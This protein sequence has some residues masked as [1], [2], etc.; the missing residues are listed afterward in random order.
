MET[1][2]VELACFRCGQ[3][4]PA[5]L[6]PSIKLIQERPDLWLPLGERPSRQIGVLAPKDGVRSGPD[7]PAAPCYGA[8]ILCGCG[9]TL[10]PC[11]VTDVG[12]GQRRALSFALGDWPTFATLDYVAL[13]LVLEP[14]APPWAGADFPAQIE[15]LRC[16][17]PRQRAVRAYLRVLRL[18]GGLGR[19]PDRSLV[20]VAPSKRAWI[21]R[22]Q[23]GAHG[24]GFL[25][26]DDESTFQWI[27]GAVEDLVA[28]VQEERDF[29]A[30]AEWLVGYRK[31]TV[32]V[33]D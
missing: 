25:R 18:W 30:A 10:L 1:G 17:P 16:L 14:P 15:D 4:H 27:D 20:W 13:P 2:H 8:Q 33:G 32:V 26:A 19:S 29:A 3:R 31:P 28:S 22:L 5:A 21:S 24:L 12:A 23:S 11:T 7:E 6:P 9:V